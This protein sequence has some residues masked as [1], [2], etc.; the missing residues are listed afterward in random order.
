MIGGMGTTPTPDS[1]WLRIDSEPQLFVDDI[2]I[3]SVENLKRTRHAPQKHAGNPVL[4]PTEPWEHV[5][6]TTVNGFQVL[7]DPKEGL[8]KCWYMDTIFSGHRAGDG[9]LGDSRYQMLYAESE[10]GIRWTKPRIG[11]RYEGEATNIILP[12]GYG[13]TCV[14]DP[15]AEE[16][17]R[18]RGLYTRFHQGG[19]VDSVVAVTSSDGRKWQELSSRPSFGKHGS[20]LD[21]VMVM[22]YDPYGRIF[23]I[24]T[25]HYDMY[26]VAQNLDNPRIAGF[27]LPHYPL[28]WARMAKRRVWQ[29]DSADAVHWSEPYLALAPRDGIEGVDETYYGMSRYRVASNLTLGF[30]SVFRQVDNTLDTKLVYSRDGRNWHYLNY[31]TSFLSRGGQEE[32]DSNILA[33]PTHPIPMGD[34]IL[35]FYGGAI[36]HHDWW[37][38]GAREGLDVPEARDRSKVRYAVGLAELRRDGFFSLEATIRPGILITRPFI[39]SGRSLVINARTRPGG[40]IRAEVCTL[41][42]RVLPGFSKE[43]CDPFDGDAVD[44]LVSWRGRTVLPEVPKSRAS[45]PEPESLRMRKVRF[46]MEKSEIY[47]FRLVDEAGTGRSPGAHVAGE[48]R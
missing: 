21:D 36:N 31:D 15:H 46:F 48:H 17:H 35:F 29:C 19:D 18:F 40:S 11:V 42:N 30:V 8:F 3:E 47:S 27:T 6:E 4:F 22:S 33:M 37:L 41:D 7:H 26:A 23:T 28:D 44:H 14:L 5:T 16:E 9:I 24:A 45:Y 1:T 12:D 20:H 34:R 13:L 2:I 25:R 10:D 32:W 43:D 39:S 38:V